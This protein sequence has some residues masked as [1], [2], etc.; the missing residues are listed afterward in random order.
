MG[1]E[2]SKSFADSVSYKILLPQ[3][4]WRYQTEETMEAALAK[5]LAGE[6]DYVIADRKD[7][8]DLMPPHPPKD[9]EDE[10]LPYP[11]LRYWPIWTEV[12]ASPYCRLRR[13]FPGA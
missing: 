2:A 4:A 10:A 9:D 13:H 3:Q 7:L 5:L 8:D 11:E 1:W 6:V 12:K